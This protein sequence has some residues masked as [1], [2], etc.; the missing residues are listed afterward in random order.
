MAGLKAIKTPLLLA[1][2]ETLI[3]LLPILTPQLVI[4]HSYLHNVIAVCSGNVDADGNVTACVE[5]WGYDYI[6]VN[7]VTVVLSGIALLALFP[8]GGYGRKGKF[9]HW[10]YVF[11]LIQIV[12]IVFAS[13]LYALAAEAPVGGNGGISWTLLG[14]SVVATFYLTAED[15]W[16]EAIGEPK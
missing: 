13:V 12:T 10:S 16:L 2:G 9:T 7:I 8:I 14:L 6:E 1:I 3:G 5:A 11:A 15:A 4:N